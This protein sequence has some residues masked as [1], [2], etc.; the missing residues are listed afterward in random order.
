MAYSYTTNPQYNENYNLSANIV[1][2]DGMTCGNVVC[3][4]MICENSVKSNLIVQKTLTANVITSNVIVNGNLTSGNIS[5]S[6]KI[7]SL[8]GYIDAN[9]NN[10]TVSTQQLNV[11]Y[12]T[13]LQGSITADTN[14]LKLY[15]AGNISIGSTNN[16]TNTTDCICIG[17][18]NNQSNTQDAYCIGENNIQ[19]GWNSLLIGQSITGGFGGTLIGRA[20]TNTHDNCV[21]INTKSGAHGITTDGNDRFFV[22]PVRALLNPGSGSHPQF[23]LWYNT[24]SGEICYNP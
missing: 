4:T 19:N 18:N 22:K 6:G 12:L 24:T 13:N 10:D 7:S 3:N 8:T 15:S 17:K 20:I 14:L 2:C 1:L 5:F 23:S 16:T 11:S 9:L 21:C